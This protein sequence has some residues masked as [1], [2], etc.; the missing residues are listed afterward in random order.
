M[1]AGFR[2]MHKC[3]RE[4]LG[5]KDNIVGERSNEWKHLS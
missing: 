4:I 5:R 2:Q 1:C 3:T